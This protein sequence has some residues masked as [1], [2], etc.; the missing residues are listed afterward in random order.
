M[1]T[2]GQK[3]AI[4]RTERS[5]LPEVDLSTVKFGRTFSD[6]MFLWDYRD[7]AWQ[8]PSI[9]PFADLEMS[10]ASLVLH[11]AQTIFEGLKAY[12]APGGRV[13]LFRPYMN[14]K[15]MNHSAH[16][17]CMPEIP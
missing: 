14:V 7:G 15:R 16:R 13:N 10:P 17:M 4:Q 9:V 6:H 11:Y 5:R 1:I 12:R 8:Q 2:T 3:I